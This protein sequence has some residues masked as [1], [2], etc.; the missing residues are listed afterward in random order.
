MLRTQKENQNEAL[1]LLDDMLDA[2]E[3]VGNVDA[4]VIVV[5][6]LTRAIDNLKGIMNETVE[7][8]DVWTKPERSRTQGEYRSL[9][10]L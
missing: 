2:L 7:F 10:R 5:D 6:Q 8:V 9:S 3:L 1:D 4:K